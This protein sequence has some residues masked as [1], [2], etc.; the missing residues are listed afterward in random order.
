MPAIYPIATTRISDALIQARLISQ[1]DFDQTELLRIQDQISTGYRISAPS[2]DAPAAIRA[3]TLQRLLDHKQQ[4]KVNLNTTQSFVSATETALVGANDLLSHVKALALRSIDSTTTP[5]QREILRSEVRNA[6]QQFL[7]IGNRKFRGRFLFGGSDNSGEPFEQFGRFVA[8][9][10]NETQLRNYIDIDFLSNTNVTGA[11]AF[12]AISAEVRGSTDLNPIL[13]TETR[14]DALRGGK[15]ISRGSFIVSDGT[16][17]KTID[18]SNAETIGDVM[19]L[20]V[21]NPPDGRQLAVSLSSNGLVVDIDDAGGGNLTIREIPGGT[22]ANELGILENNG[23]GVAALTGDDLDP[24]LELTTQLRDILGTRAFVRATFPGQHGDI[25]IEAANNGPTFNNTTVQFVAGAVGD[26]A[27]ASYDSLT[28]TL[29]VQISP[30]VTRAT[31][32][33]AAINASGVFT[34]ELDTVDDKFN[35]GSD[36]LTLA[37]FSTAGGSGEALDKTSGIQIV[38]GDDTFTITFDNCETVED[39]LNVLNRSNARVLASINSTGTGIDVRSRLSGADF[40]IGE[41]GGTT[42]SQLGIRSLTEATFLSD[43]NYEFGIQEDTGADLIIQRRDGVKLQI[44]LSSAETVGDVLDL[45]NNDPANVGNAVVARLAPVGNGIELEDANAA[46][47]QDLIVSRGSNYAAWWLGLVPKNQDQVVAAAVAP[48]QPQLISGS[49]VNPLEAPGVF[50]SLLRLDQALEDFDLPAL[51]RAATQL[52]ENFVDLTFVQAEL[53]SKAN[54]LTTFQERI[55]REDIEI[56]STLS[57]EI[58]TDIVKAIA[59]LTA[60]QANLEASLKLV[61]ATSQLSVL[62]YL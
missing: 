29:T 48:G 37:T 34:A 38:N 59:E 41:N 35:D 33:V 46:G 39:L 11:D 44:D 61:V 6:I 52:D 8:Y 45:I 28:N 42:A 19:E 53:G 50:N 55:D 1:F 4:A 54:S 20:L 14:L 32:A 60:R 5:A 18:I 47:A 49:D 15:G 43:L 51:E 36:V 26:T 62:N 22:T 9:N 10:A 16:S 58:D 27:N 13:T 3:I 7:D 12:G 23:V 17:V 25:R 21:A 24:Q 30:S 31:T 2:Q 57:N 56:R 40:K